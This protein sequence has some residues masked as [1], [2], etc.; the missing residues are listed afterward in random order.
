MDP[1]FS[2]I[3]S[4]LER[5][6]LLRDVPCSVLVWKSVAH[7]ACL[8][9][10]TSTLHKESAFSTMFSPIPL[11][12]QASPTGALKK[13]FRKKPSL[14][15]EAT[16][17]SPDPGRKWDLLLATSMR[18][19]AALLTSKPFLPKKC[20]HPSAVLNKNFQPKRKVWATQQPNGAV[21]ST[22]QARI[23]VQILNP[24]LAAVAHR[25]SKFPEGKPPHEK[26]KLRLLLL[27][28]LS[29]FHTDLTN[30]V[31]TTQGVP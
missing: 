18:W 30:P 28:C 6:G 13:A 3:L 19:P 5:T 10:R 17:I 9:S 2:F 7:T 21:K 24:A 26:R 25:L 11:P 27:C 15:E 14:G 20:P 23:A 1:S 29:F 31:L 22:L 4:T 16:M 12:A 8:Q